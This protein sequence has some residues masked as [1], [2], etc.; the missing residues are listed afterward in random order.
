MVELEAAMAR[1]STHIETLAIDLITV[2]APGGS[3]KPGG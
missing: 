2:R 1:L 3:F